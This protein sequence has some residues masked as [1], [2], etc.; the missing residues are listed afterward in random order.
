MCVWNPGGGLWVCGGQ[1]GAEI[2][3]FNII[4]MIKMH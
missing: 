1:T 4:S 3:D 2:M